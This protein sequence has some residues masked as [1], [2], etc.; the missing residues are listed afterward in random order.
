MARLVWVPRP[1][2]TYVNL[3]EKLPKEIVLGE[4][5]GSLTFIQPK[6]TKQQ[7]FLNHLEV[8]QEH[9]NE[10]TRFVGME[11]LPE[12]PQGTIVVKDYAIKGEVDIH[13][14]NTHINFPGEGEISVSLGVP[15]TR[16]WEVYTIKYRIETNL[17]ETES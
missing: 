7:K 14:K 12:Q 13:S 6:G 10:V 4:G 9:F 5:T 16:T 8:P 3:S 11:D 17:P 2:N 1:K 15:D